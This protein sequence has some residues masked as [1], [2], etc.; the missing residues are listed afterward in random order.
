MFCQTCNRTGA[1]SRMSAPFILS[2]HISRRSID[3]G[4]G[5][6][7]LSE[8][9][10]RREREEKKGKRRE[11]VGGGQAAKENNSQGGGAGADRVASKVRERIRRRSLGMAGGREKAEKEAMKLVEKKIPTIQGGGNKK[12]KK[13][14]ER[15][16]LLKQKGKA[17]IECHRSGMTKLLAMVKVEM[18]MVNQADQNR[19][20]LEEYLNCL[21]E[22]VERKRDVVGAQSA[23][24][25]EW[26][27]AR[28]MVKDMG[29]REEE[30]E[31]IDYLEELGQE[32]DLRLN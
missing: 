24:L 9:L 32:E 15:K 14:T 2:N 18:K 20:F 19:D 11:S 1:S 22:L 10:E 13:E 3:G 23:K 28:E 21:E 8:A 6:G 16:L 4:G 30:E 26:K 12:E 7:R 17:L 31:D 25:Q 27:S 29:G 5:G